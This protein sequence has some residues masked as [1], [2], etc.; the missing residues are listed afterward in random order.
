VLAVVDD[1]ITL[2]V[3]P[4]ATNAEITLLTGLVFGNTVRDGT[5][6]LDV[7]NYPNS[8][9]FND[10]SAELNKLIETRVLPKLRETAKT[11]ATIRFAGCAEVVDESTDLRP[12]RLI[13]IQAE[14]E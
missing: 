7:N 3:T 6:L 12:L 5:G 14:I 10:I 9:D 1:E 4:G 11:G 8:Q 2:A 13:P